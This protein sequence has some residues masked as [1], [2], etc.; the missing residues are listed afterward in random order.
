VPATKAALGFAAQG[1][2]LLRS[3]DVGDEHPD[4]KRNHADARTS[5]ELR[6]YQPC[7]AKQFKTP[8]M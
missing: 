8:V 6:H 1:D 7:C 5:T 2:T 4:Q 3:I